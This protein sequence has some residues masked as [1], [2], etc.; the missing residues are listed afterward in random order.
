MGEFDPAI[1][2]LKKS[3]AESLSDGETALTIRIEE[4]KQT[5]D[6]PHLDS[7]DQSQFKH[8]SLTGSSEVI[9]M[10]DVDHGYR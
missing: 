10:F 9:E 6:L 5:I 8:E 7:I 1:M 3:V 2:L 4:I